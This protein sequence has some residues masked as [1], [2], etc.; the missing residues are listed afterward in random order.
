MKI[1][2]ALRELHRSETAL[3]EELY[4]VAE[5]HASD[6][7]IYHLG[8]D[9]AGWSVDHV[10]RIAEI[11]R[12]YGEDLDPEPVREGGVTKRLR[13][14][15]SD[16]VGRS[17]PPALALLTDLREVYTMAQGVSVDW[18]LLAQAAQ[19]IRHHDLLDLTQHCHPENLRQARWANAQLKESAT[20]IL[21]S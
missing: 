14:A 18:E 4:R 19:G 21:V 8:R 2:L 7:E 15:A 20:Q 9:L 17:G 16:A 10:R 3:A 6:H 11:A 5:R 13:E 1:G 12:A